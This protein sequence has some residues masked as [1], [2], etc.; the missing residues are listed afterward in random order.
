MSTIEEQAFEIFLIWFSYSLK[1]ACKGFIIYTLGV[2]LYKIIRAC[3]IYIA[4]H[5]DKCFIKI[6]DTG[7]RVFKCKCGT[8]NKTSHS[9]IKFHEIPNSDNCRIRDFIRCESCDDT[10]ITD[11]ILIKRCDKI[12]C[13]KCDRVMRSM[14]DGL[15]K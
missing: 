3:N 4:S 2:T 5:E 8:L 1:L 9:E 10:I 6:D 12:D 15:N 7:N 11:Y 13:E 14:C